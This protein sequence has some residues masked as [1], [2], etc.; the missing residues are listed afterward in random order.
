MAFCSNCG[1]PVDEKFAFCTCCGAKVTKEAPVQDVEDAFGQ[2]EVLA[3][4]NNA[5]VAEEPITEN[6]IQEEVKEPEA[7]EELPAE[8][9]PIETA[10]VEEVPPVVTEPRETPAV[11]P[12]ATNVYEAP[13][14]TGYTNVP[15]VQEEPQLPLGKD[16]V[17]TV[18]NKKGEFGV[19]GTCYYFFMTLLYAIPFVGLI[20]AIVMSFGGTV[21]RS[22]RG[23]ARAVLIYKI[24][25]IVLILS[26]LIAL[27]FLQNA[28]FEMLSDYLSEDIYS[29]SELFDLL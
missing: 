14:A 19:V 12:A 7:V 26:A 29:W 9:T 2:T 27:I 18:P 1:S 8:E 25:G 28:L 24:I 22:K 15:P 21:N 6:T 3:V 23:F 13:P 11:N 16:T 17:E 20:M 10:P 5:P 4:E